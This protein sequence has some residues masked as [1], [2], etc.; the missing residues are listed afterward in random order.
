[1]EGAAWSLGRWGWFL[2]ISGVLVCILGCILFS[3]PLT[4]PVTVVTMSRLL[5]SSSPRQ[6]SDLASLLR[7][8]YRHCIRIRNNRT[9]LLWDSRTQGI[10]GAGGRR[11]RE[12]HS[13][14]GGGRQQG[15]GGIGKGRRGG[16]GVV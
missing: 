15:L 9:L 10:P 13:R 7:L 6:T 11:Q 8:V 5:P 1:M 12:P 16:R 3:F 4:K 14:L 2:N